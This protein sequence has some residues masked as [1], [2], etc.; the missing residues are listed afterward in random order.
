MHDILA[1]YRV[2]SLTMKLL[3]VELI[4]VGDQRQQE[5]KAS[6][7]IGDRDEEDIRHEKLLFVC[8]YT[9]FNLA[10]NVLVEEKVCCAI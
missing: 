8:V 10:S 9:L 7:G 6:K 1:D 2:G 4:Q 5:K 3:D